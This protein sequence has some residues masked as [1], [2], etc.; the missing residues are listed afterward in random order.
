MRKKIVAIILLTILLVTMLTGCASW[1]R[2]WKS[3][4]SDLSGGL[5]RT[6]TVYDYNGNVIKSWSGIFDISESEN[7]IFFDLNGKRIIV[8]GGIIIAEEN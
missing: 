7:E 2:S 5:N 3:F 6:V 1:S 8:Q 4:T